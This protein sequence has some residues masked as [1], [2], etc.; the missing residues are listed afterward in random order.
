MRQRGDAEL[1]VMWATNNFWPKT[2]GNEAVLSRFPLIAWLTDE[3]FDVSEIVH[4]HMKSMGGLLSLD[5]PFPDATQIAKVRGWRPGDEVTQAVEDV[6][7]VL[8]EEIS[9]YNRPDSAFK[10]LVRPRNFRQWSALL[11]RLS[12]LR[13]DDP[14]PA[15][16]HEDAIGLL[17]YAWPTHDESEAAAWQSITN[18]ICDPLQGAIN[19]IFATAHEKMRGYNGDPSEKAIILGRYLDTAKDNLRDLARRRN[20]INPATNEYTDP[21]IKKCESDLLIA[22]AEIVRG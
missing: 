13:Y 2:E 4:Q 16:V 7:G 22:M 19:N 6:I 17:A 5:Y 9:N 14:N 20:L 1:P 3:E 18:K 11:Y 12:C 8:V 21:R 10:F 15:V